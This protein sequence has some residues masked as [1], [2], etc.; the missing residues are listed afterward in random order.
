MYITIFC[1]AWEIGESYLEDIN[2]AVIP[3]QTMYLSTGDSVTF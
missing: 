3:V 1:S 2:K